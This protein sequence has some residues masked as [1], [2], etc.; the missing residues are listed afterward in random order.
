M[1]EAA[2]GPI[3]RSDFS[4]E[5][6]RTSADCIVIKLTIGAGNPPLQ[7][8]AGSGLEAGKLA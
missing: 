4:A 7:G 8:R 1:I 5:L 3:F 2:A 6:S